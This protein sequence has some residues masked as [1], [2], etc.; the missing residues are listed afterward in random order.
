MSR[1]LRRRSLLLGV[2]AATGLAVGGLWWGLRDT[3]DPTSAATVDNDAVPTAVEPIETTAT[4]ELPVTVTDATGQEITITDISRIVPLSGAISEI[5]FTLGLGDRIVARDV[6]ATFD[7]AAD[8]P[9]ISHGHDV[10][11]EG[12]LSTQPTLI[13]TEPASADDATLD[14]LRAAGATIATFDSVTD[15]AGINPRIDAIATALGVPQ[16]GYDLIEHTDQRISSAA[17]TTGE[18][19]PLRVAFLYLRGSASVYFLGGTNSGASDIIEAAGGIDAGKE[20]GLEGDFVPLTPEAMAA[21]QP[22]AFLTMT[23][24]LDSVGGV[25]GLLQLAGVAQ[26]PAGQNRRVAAIADGVLLNYGPRTADVI[27]SLSAQI[28]G[29][30]Q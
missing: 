7:Q 28:H 1:R 3:P 9:L 25:D 19:P 30:V 29:S 6:T 5:V 10:S 22:D 11:V 18:G 17:A 2:P 12:V 4:P 16:A 27:T 15:L 8:L 13:L 21:A 23:K 14:Q 20:A 26:T 24:G